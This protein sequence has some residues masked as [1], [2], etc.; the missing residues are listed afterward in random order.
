MKIPRYKNNTDMPMST[1][2][3]GN[4]IDSKDLLMW[5]DNEGD[6]LSR[7]KNKELTTP[8]DIE[9]LQAQIEILKKLRKEID[10]GTTR[11]K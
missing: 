5:I 8:I 2:P 6:I 11:R 9:R 4:W 10:N 7:E 3:D 1:E